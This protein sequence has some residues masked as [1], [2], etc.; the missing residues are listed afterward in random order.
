MSSTNFTGAMHVKFDVSR[1]FSTS[2]IP[3][4]QPPSQL[5]SAQGCLPI[6][7]PTLARRAAQ[8]APKSDLAY[9]HRII[10]LHPPK[11]VWPPDFKRLSAQE[12]LRFEKK[13]KRRLALATA[14]PRWDKFVKLAQLFSIVCM[15]GC[16]PVLETGPKGFCSE[17][18]LFLSRAHVLH[19]LHGLGRRA[20]TFR[21]CKWSCCPT[22]AAHVH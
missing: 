12:Q 22:E 9:I 6:M 16:V 8:N 7:F 3:L 1:S 18:T 10:E 20:P 15:L 2:L 4:H 21:W 5:T 19:P 17:L 14:R 13:F 11:K